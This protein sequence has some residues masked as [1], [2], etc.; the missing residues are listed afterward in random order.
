MRIVREFREFALKGNVVDL[1][2]GVIIGAAFGAVVKSLVDDIIM[3]VIGSAVGGVD[4]G[5]RFYVIKGNAGNATTVANARANGAAVF[6][7]GQFI[8]TCITFVIVAFAVFMMIKGMNRM[9]RKS[10]SAPTP[11]TKPCPHCD[12][13]ISIKASKCPHCTTTL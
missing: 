13:V 9:R 12:S 11:T 1:A 3:P 7:Y 5:G 4:F 8:N 6:A 10:E 2:V